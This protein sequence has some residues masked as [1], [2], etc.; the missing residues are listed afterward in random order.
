MTEYVNQYKLLLEMTSWLDYK[1]KE[2]YNNLD[3][4]NWISIR[5]SWLKA[6]RFALCH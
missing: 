1:P 6:M 5:I 2:L 4:V 3:Q